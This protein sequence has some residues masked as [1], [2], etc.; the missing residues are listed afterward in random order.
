MGENNKGDAGDGTAN[1]D[2]NNG[3]D[4]GF[5]S[6]ESKRRVLGDLAK[7][8]AKRQELAAK[9]EQMEKAASDAKNGDGGKADS[10]D[11][12]I[13]KLEKALQASEAR[14]MRSEV[15]A[16]KG[17]SPDQAQFLS[18]GNREEMEASADRLVDTFGL[19]TGSNNDGGETDET[20]DGRQAA[21]DER[22]GTGRPKEKL[23]SGANNPGEDAAVDADK[24]AEAVLSRQ[25]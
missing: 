2:G 20:D 21:E 10:T 8:R 14:V 23:H 1:D 7:E 13:S 24:I 18:G 17:L 22:K 4:E 12:R 9:V 6:E 19:N 16:A 5:K 11:D 15:A 3:S 25:F